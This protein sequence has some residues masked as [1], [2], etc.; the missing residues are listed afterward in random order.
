MAPGADGT[1]LL[2]CRP[3][4]AAGLPPRAP[5]RV[6]MGS[7]TGARTQASPLPVR[8]STQRPGCC[9]VQP[10][11]RQKHKEVA[12]KEGLHPAELGKHCS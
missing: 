11:V 2:L 5:G 7:D 12:R 9:L 3:R 8:V 1:M 10:H 6:S 4:L